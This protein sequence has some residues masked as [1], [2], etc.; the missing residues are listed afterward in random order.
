VLKNR[1]TPELSEANS[2][3]RHSH[4]RK[5]LKNIH[6]MMLTSFCSLTKTYWQFDSGHTE[7]DTEWPIVCTAINQED[8]A[9]K[10]P[11]TQLMFSH[12]SWVT[13]GSHYT[14]LFLVDHGLKV[15]EGY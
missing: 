14:S 3:A 12:W 4:S 13:C 8:V 10:G 5:L 9:T 6:P 15:S 11:Q 1:Y 7:K 2:H